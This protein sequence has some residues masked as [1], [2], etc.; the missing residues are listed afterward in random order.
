[1]NLVSL[2]EKLDNSHN[3]KDAVS[4]IFINFHSYQ[5]ERLKNAS[6]KD[7]F[8]KNNQ[9]RLLISGF[10]KTEH[11]TGKIQKQYDDAC[12]KYVWEPMVYYVGNQFGSLW[13]FPEN[14][15]KIESDKEE[16]LDFFG[17][18]KNFQGGVGAFEVKSSNT[19]LNRND[20]KGQ[21]TKC[22]GMIKR[23][24][25]DYCILFECL[26]KSKK[27]KTKFKEISN[28]V[29]QISGEKI[30]EKIT[31]DNNYYYKILKEINDFDKHFFIKERE[32]EVR[33][34]IQEARK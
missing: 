15:Q 6:F 18:L 14:S 16:R 21:I 4:S 7:F 23:K 25:Y 31:T 11:I 32:R 5:I 10:S 30:W 29:F 26:S 33:R 2:Y 19:T 13:K 24:Q 12:G 1:M 17:E 9:T 34:I 8:D 3:L 28:N 22:E 27:R 20:K